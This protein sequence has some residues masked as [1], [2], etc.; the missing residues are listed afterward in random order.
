MR[1][2]ACIARALFSLAHAFGFANGRFAFDAA[3]M[4]LIAL[5]ALI[6][7]WLR[8]RTGSVLLPV[9]LHK[10]GNSVALVA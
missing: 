10:F 8:L 7:V 5:P 1:H 3:T 4:A 9:V 6:A 2:T